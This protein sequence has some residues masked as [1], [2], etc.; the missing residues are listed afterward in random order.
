MLWGGLWGEHL[1]AEHERD[2]EA[3]SKILDELPP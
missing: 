2:R 3:G 1:S